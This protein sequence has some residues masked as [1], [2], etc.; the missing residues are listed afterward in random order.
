MASSR[1]TTVL[2]HRE[3]TGASLARNQHSQR[4]KSQT[5]SCQ[6]QKGVLHVFSSAES[7]RAWPAGRRREE[8]LWLFETFLTTTRCARREEERLFHFFRP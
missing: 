4:Y 2:K 1:A 3:T 7:I 8:K 5:K 6:K